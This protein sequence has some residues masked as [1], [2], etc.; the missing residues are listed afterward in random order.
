MPV[1]RYARAT[2]AALRYARCEWPVGSVGLGGL[3]MEVLGLDGLI[4]CVVCWLFAC[5][6]VC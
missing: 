5:L 4:V 3:E 2:R 1:L 6:F